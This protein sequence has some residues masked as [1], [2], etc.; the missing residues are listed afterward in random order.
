MFTIPISAA[1]E[2]D[3]YEPFDPSGRTLSSGL[4]AYLA[5]FVEDREVG[6]EVCVELACAQAI[7]ERRFRESYLGHLDSLARRCSTRRRKRAANA[8]RLLAI[9]VVFVVAGL[10]LAGKVGPV[11]AAIIS[12]IGSFS[13]WEA[14]AIWLEDIPSLR[15][16]ERVLGV[17]RR[18]S[19]EFK[20]CGLWCA[21]YP[22]QPTTWTKQDFPYSGYAKGCT[23]VAW[24]FTD[25]LKIAGMS[26]DGDAVYITPAQWAKY[27]N[28]KK[29]SS[30]K[31][32]GG[33]KMSLPL[34][35]KFAQVMEHLCSHDGDGGH[36]YT[37]GARWGDGTYE[38]I[39]LSD[40]STARIANGDRDCSSGII[41]ALEAVG[42]DCRGASY[43]GN[44]R[45]CLLA[46][47]L[48]KRVPID[49]QPYA[50][51]GDIYLNEGCHTAMCTSDKPDTLCQFSISENGTIYGA[52]G[53]QTGDESNFRAYYSYPWDGRLE[54]IDREASGGGAPVVTDDID[55]LANDII[56]GVFGNGDARKAALGDKYDAVQ[57]RVNQMLG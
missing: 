33:K 25:K 24:Q 29:S 31:A 11:P 14:A 54:W 30:D 50:Q 9:G 2:S 10:V 57:A 38:T 55:K 19:I 42:V 20:A 40:G 37:Q 36:G 3:L 18:A 21:G 16:R 4:Q 17:Y 6:Q 46:T 32:N 7:D 28:P 23:V 47:G 49:K 26:V 56:N 44:M 53:D 39:T 41:S 13:I 48:F 8:L 45:E 27:A 22:T 5:S 51:R 12:T 34:Y 52:Q 15:K 35:E 43:T 1:S